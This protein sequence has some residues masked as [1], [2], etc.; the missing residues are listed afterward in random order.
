MKKSLL[1][2]VLAIAILLMGAV[3][4]ASA[5]TAV[6]SKNG[7][8][9]QSQTATVTVKAAVESKLELTVVTPNNTQT[10][11]FGTVDPGTPVNSPAI[12]VTVKSNR[13]YDLSSAT[14]GQV[15]AM[16]L[17]TLGLT[18]S[19]A[20]PTSG[21]LYNDTYSLNVPWTTAPGNYTATVQY[22]VTQR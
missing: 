22:T 20:I 1:L 3:A 8:G 12:N 10:V 19:N 6:Y 9:I 11:D 4:Y 15:A 2:G 16:G 17:T 14:A 18:A 7:V 13:N 21:T 5:D